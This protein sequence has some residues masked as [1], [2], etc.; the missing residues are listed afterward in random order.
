LSRGFR[1][2]VLIATA[3]ASLALCA[4]AQAA[5]VTIGE[6]APANPPAFCTNGPYDGAPTGS[7]AAASTVPAEGV[8]TSWST[9][10]AEGSGQTET[11]KVYRPLGGEKYL[12]VGHDGPQ[13][14]I[15]STLNTFKTSIPVQAG[16]VIG[17]DDDNATIVHNACLFDTATKTDTAFFV[18][19]EASDGATITVEGS[20]EGVLNNLT[21]TVVSPPT[22]SSIA[23]AMGPIAGNTPV[24]IAGANFTGVSAVK[25][26]ATPATSYTVISETAITAVSPLIAVPGTVDTSVTAAGGTTEASAADKF[27]YALPAP[28]PTCTVPQ[29][30]GKKLKA[31]K[32]G[33]TKADCKLGKVKKLKGATAKTG[34]VVKQSPKAGKVL[35]AGSK[36]NVKLG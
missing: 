30:T 10:A 2:P 23:P 13:A 9:N 31:A 36:V 12:V 24:T 3:V 15:P 27:S 29:L 21:A 6:L 11:F 14:L 8:I 22:I 18:A 33:L 26:G 28:A 1:V 16:D 4:S 5:P 35:A 34:K 32:K 19:G 20:E 17:S 7:A 25:F